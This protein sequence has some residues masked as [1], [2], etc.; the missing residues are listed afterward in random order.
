MTN[1]TPPPGPDYDKDGIEVV[2]LSDVDLDFIVE[3]AFRAGAPRP[4]QTTRTEPAKPEELAAL[5]IFHG[6]GEQDLTALAAQCQSIHSV[7]GHVVVAPGRLNT[8]VFFVLEGQLRLY[9]HTAD[10]RPIAITDIGQST[11]L[12]SALVMQPANHS[13]IAT[14]VSHIIAID[15]AALDDLTKRSHA[16]AC[17]YA[18]LLASYLRGDNCVHVGARSQSGAARQGYIDELTLLHNQHWLDTVYPRL[19]ARCRLGDAP[20]AVTAFAID[21]LDEIIKAHGTDAGLRVLQAVSHWML[22]QTRPTDILAINKNRYIFAFLP[23][24]TLDA[25]RQLA[26]RVKTQIPTVPIP[27]AGGKD[28]ITVTFAIGIAELE[29]GMKDSEL[30][31]N[32]EAL[33]QKSIKLGGNWLSEALE[34]PEGTQLTEEQSRTSEPDSSSPRNRL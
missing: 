16:F 10:K 18:A 20:L 26:D 17:N 13:V 11:G 29:K 22:D 4:V 25:A 34:T 14:E 19:I 6:L 32:T 24:C 1:T 9:P 5:E 8:K 28:P 3:D 12:R 30:M 31:A 15:L 23:D 2:E 7:P 21:K 27:L 33:I